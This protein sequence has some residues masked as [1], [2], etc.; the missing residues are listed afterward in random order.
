[1]AGRLSNEV[2]ATPEPTLQ[3]AGAN[4]TKMSLLNAIFFSSTILSMSLFVTDYRSLETKASLV[5]ITT[6]NF[7]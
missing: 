6:S 1:M 2:G 7:Q 4:I 3:Y 5:W